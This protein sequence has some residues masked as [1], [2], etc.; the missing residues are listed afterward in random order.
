MALHAN[1]EVCVLREGY[2]QKRRV[3]GVAQQVLGNMPSI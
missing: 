3:R 2:L 1:V